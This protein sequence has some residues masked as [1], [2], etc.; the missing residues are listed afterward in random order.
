MGDGDPYKRV[1]PGDDL[2]ISAGAWNEVLDMLRERKLGKQ[3]PLPVRDSGPD[4][5]NILWVKNNTGYPRKRWDVVVLDDT[6]TYTAPMFTAVLGGEALRS[7]R[8]K[9]NYVSAIAPEFPNHLGRF[10]VL[11]QPLD[12]GKIGRAVIDGVTPAWVVANGFDMFG[13]IPGWADIA[14]GDPEEEDEEEKARLA[15]GPL[16]PRL[17]GGA[18]ILWV[19][20]SNIVGES[21]DDDRK[22]ALV[23]LGHFHNDGFLAKV[24]EDLLP[25]E[26]ANATPYY[27][28]ADG[29][30]FP[31]VVDIDVWWPLSVPDGIITNNSKVWCQASRHSGLYNV[32]TSEQFYISPQS[33]AVMA[34]YRPGDTVRVIGGP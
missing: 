19:A 29:E 3:P 11:Q 7:F 32:A 15:C 10:A 18:E 28:L 17:Y 31:E 22:L 16:E 30:W 33:A 24:N 13:G 20:Q 26:S 14:T 12:V 5:R 1:M 9:P 27:Q 21:Y 8:E 2:V 4:D 34:A 6:D 23:R 25:G